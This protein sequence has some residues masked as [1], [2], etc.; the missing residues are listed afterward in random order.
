MDDFP[1][2]VSTGEEALSLKKRFEIKSGITFVR[3]SD[4]SANFL[5]PTIRVLVIWERDNAIE[6]KYYDYDPRLDG[7]E[8]SWV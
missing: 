7:V 4:C 3:S 2:F 6:Y 5:T 1:S 8:A